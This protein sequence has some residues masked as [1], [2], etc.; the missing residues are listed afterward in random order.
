MYGAHTKNKSIFMWLKVF[1]SG[2]R[3]SHKCTDSD[4]GK[5]YTSSFFLVSRLV[6]SVSSKSWRCDF[7][8][9]LFFPSHSD[10]IIFNLVI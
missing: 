1:D 4:S 10:A 3:K 7:L 9:T 5:V 6:L 8:P 2:Y